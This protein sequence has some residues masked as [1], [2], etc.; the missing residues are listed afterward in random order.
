M[1]VNGCCTRPFLLASFMVAISSSTHASNDDLVNERFFE[2]GKAIEVHWRI[3]CAKTSTAVSAFLNKL[4]APWQANC[5]AFG[6]SMQ[7][8]ELSHLLDSLQKCGFIYN[9]KGSRR[10]QSCPNYALAHRGLDTMTAACRDGLVNLASGPSLVRR[11]QA[12]LT[13]KQ[14]GLPRANCE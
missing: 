9:I 6:G 4:A 10:F 11:T 12:A 2:P 13:C 1:I 7:Q 8:V 5:A 3:D 14:D